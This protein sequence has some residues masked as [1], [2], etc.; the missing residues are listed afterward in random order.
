MLR[1]GSK[2]MWGA[3]T[4]VT[5][6]S[7]GCGSDGLTGPNGDLSDND[8]AAIVQALSSTG[9]LTGSPAAAF[10]SFF[11]DGLSGLG[12]M[13]A[14]SAAQVDQAVNAGLNMALSTGAAASYDG[15]GFL[16]GYDISSGGTSVTGW[17][18]GIVGFNNL[19]TSANT[20]DNL[21][22]AFILG[23]DGTT[24]PANTSGTIGDVSAFATYYGSSTSYFGNSGTVGITSSAFSGGSTNCGGSA[25]GVTVTCSVTSGTMAGNFAFQATSLGG[26]QTF[27]QVP[28]D[29]QNLPAVNVQISTT[30]SN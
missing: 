10:A 24:P 9:G 17:M 5:L 25:Q 29:F 20:V 8:K 1:K 11:V 27:T 14:S 19:N 12:Q 6:V 15:F 16:I 28:I 4:V 18:A 23:T 7:M 13:T 21:V 30:L 26:A 3:V 22:S 2:F